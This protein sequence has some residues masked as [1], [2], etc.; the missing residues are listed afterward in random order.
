MAIQHELDLVFPTGKVT[1]PILC[2]M[3]RSYD[4]VFNIQSAN[5]SRERGHFHF[6]LIGE[7]GAVRSAEGYLREQGIEVKAIRSGPY[8]GKVPAKPT[9]QRGKAGEVTVA[10]KL[11]VTF[12]DALR[13]EP[14]T[15]EMAS[16]FDVTFDVRQSSTGE[17]VSIMAVLLEGPGSQVEGAIAYLRERGAEVE[18]IEKTVIEG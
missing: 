10:K 5:V 4:V 18:P 7:E 16:R 13:R 9:L 6:T 8:A 1:E 15:W 2:R 17:S 14:V 12:P 11:W 3:A